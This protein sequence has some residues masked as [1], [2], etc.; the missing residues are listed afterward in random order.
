MVLVLQGEVAVAAGLN[1]DHISAIHR[2]GIYDV[3]I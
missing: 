3:I 1:D 2:A